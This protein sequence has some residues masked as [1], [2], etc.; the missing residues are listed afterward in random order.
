[1]IAVVG[2]LELQNLAAPGERACQPHRIGGGFRAGG[3]IGDFLGAGDVVDQ[4]LG[5][6]HGDVVERAE[7]VRA[8]IEL[9]FRSLYHRR[10]RMPEDQRAGA[11]DVVDI[12]VAVDV[13]QA[14]APAVRVNQADIVGQRITAEAGAGQYAVGDFEKLALAARA[15]SGFNGA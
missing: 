2:A 15:S 10:M 5:E 8:A 3:G 1:M 13:P 11:A 9:R 6:H 4:S 7:H 14:R 12:L